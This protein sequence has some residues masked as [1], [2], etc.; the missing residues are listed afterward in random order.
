MRGPT[1]T[2]ATRTGLRPVLHFTPGSGWVNDPV[3]LVHHDGRYHLF[4]QYVPDS[5]TWQ[6]HCGWGHATS[7]DLVSWTEHTPALTP[8]DGDVGCWSGRVLTEPDA[9]AVL[10]YTSVN[11]PDFDL[12]VVR[13]ARPRDDDWHTWDKGEV[14]VAPPEGHDLLAFRDPSVFRD[15]PVWR[16]LVGAGY[17]DTRAAVLSYSSPDLRTWRYDGPLAERTPH[18]ADRDTGKLVWECPHLVELDGR[19]V[20]VAS[21][22]HD[23]GTGHVEAAVG[24]YADGRF[25]AEGWVRLTDGPGHYAPTPF[26]DADGRLG[27]IFWIREIADEEGGWAGAM[28]IPYLLGLRDGRVRLSPHPGVRRGVRRNP[29]SPM[30]LD[31]TPTARHAHLELRSARG[32][33]ASLDVEG[34][35]VTVTSAGR[36]AR[37]P[38]AE[39]PVA[40]LADGAVLEVCTGA[41]VAGLPVAD[42][43]RTAVASDAADVSY[44]W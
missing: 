16:M 28:S 38:R 36:S 3:G 43:T 2:R 25:T 18:P 42:D 37:L 39:G 10:H 11:E 22:L 15:G 20:L 41:A 23:G 33:T 8:G 13:D 35:T 40:V 27:L 30:G 12:G 31:W 44:W 32:T 19:H 21:V 1:P 7:T 17:A 5:T 6:P 14:L 26:T 24:N 34:T 9:D 29:A 4:Y